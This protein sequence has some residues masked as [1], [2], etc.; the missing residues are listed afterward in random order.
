MLICSCRVTVRDGKPRAVVTVAHA[1]VRNGRLFKLCPSFLYSSSTSLFSRTTCAKKETMLDGYHD[2]IA[3]LNTLVTTCPPPFIYVHDPMTPRISASNVH[4][5]LS[6]IKE[7]EGSCTIYA[8]VDAVS[9]FTPRLL[10]DTVLNAFAEWIPEWNEGCSNWSGPPEA[11]GNRYN[12]NF[13]AFLHG[14]RALHK[15]LLRKM[16]VEAGE[17]ELKIIFVIERAERLKETM[18][19]LMVPLTR[20]AELVSSSICSLLKLY[21]DQSDLY[22]VRHNLTSQSSC[23]LM[24]AGRL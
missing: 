12:E 3:D 13:D 21:C 7:Q 18:P 20:F 6:N 9:C 19:D 5:A 2:F 15:S 8:H 10:Y 1:R 11:S 23:T 24:C 14:I 16:A 22:I 4:S 17:P